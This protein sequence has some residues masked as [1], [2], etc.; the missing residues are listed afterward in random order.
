MKTAQNIAYGQPHREEGSP[1]SSGVRVIVVRGQQ[2]E[3]VAER[4]VAYEQ[5]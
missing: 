4:N 3:I 1:T 5:V 2:N